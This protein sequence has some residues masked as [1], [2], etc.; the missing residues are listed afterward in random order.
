MFRELLKSRDISKSEKDAMD[1]LVTDTLAKRLRGADKTREL[2]GLDMESKLPGT[3]I[4]SMIYT[5]MYDTEMVDKSGNYQF[6]DVVPVIL[7]MTNDNKQITGLNFNLI[8]NNVRA[9]I[10]DTIYD[11]WNTFYDKT[12]G[13]AAKDGKAVINNDLATIVSHPEMRVKFLK[14]MDDIT[15]VKVSNAYRVYSLDKISNPRMIEF[16]MWKHIPM[17]SFKDSIRGAN[18]AAVQASI[19]KDK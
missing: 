10:L 2:L 4:P 8:P 17:L 6:K 18:L 5:F 11:S 9:Y 1:Y 13:E 12:V 15:G 7:C 14:M 3:F 19:I 16:D